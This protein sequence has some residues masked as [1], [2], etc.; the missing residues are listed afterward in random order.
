[1][2]ERTTADPAWAPGVSTVAVR[3][4]A[5][6]DLA[7]VSR[8]RG[9]GFDRAELERIRRYF[10]RAGREPTDVELA[11]L[12]QSWSEH[13]SYKSSRPFLRRSFG[14]FR[15]LRRVLGTGD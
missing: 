15:S 13:C 12:A 11:A 14:P 4:R 1:M 9:W 3:T 8:S 6:T 5:I 2:G 10:R 7:R